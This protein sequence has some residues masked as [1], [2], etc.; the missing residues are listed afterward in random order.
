ME[1]TIAIL[2]VVYVAGFIITLTATLAYFQRKYPTVG[3]ETYRANL[4]L[5]VLTA[6][7]PIGWVVCLFASGF[8]KRGF[9]LFP[10]RTPK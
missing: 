4:R 7:T 2:C 8:Y 3:A 10:A 5:A 9:K 1:N 6:A